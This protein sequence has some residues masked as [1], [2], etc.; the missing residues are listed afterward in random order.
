MIEF[1]Y[2]EL[3]LFVWAVLASA[4]WYKHLSNAVTLHKLL[5]SVI[6]DP[7]LYAE[8]HESWKKFEKAFV[9]N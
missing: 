9:K 2:T 6:E 4:G 8:M 3:I 1:T 7:K 5:R